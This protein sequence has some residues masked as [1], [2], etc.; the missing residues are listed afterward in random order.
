MTIEQTLT[1]LGIGAVAGVMAGM[2][3]LGGGAIIVPA[4]MFLMG[5]SQTEANGTSL[6]ALV[7]PVGIFACIAYYRQGKLR[8]RSSAAT[9]LGL[10]MGTGIGASIALGLPREVLSV[11][12]G[13][14]LVY[15]GWRYAS[16]RQWFLET[17]GIPAP[18]V[19]EE[20]DVDTD[21]LPVIAFCVGIGVLA[22]VLGGMFGIGGGTII[23]TA[24]V[25]IG[26]DH[27]LA[28]GTSLGALLLPVGLPAAVSYYN[29][30]QLN[31]SAVLPLLSTLVVFQIFG[32]RMTLSLPASTVKRLF[33]VFLLVVSLRYLLVL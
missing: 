19:P 9:A 17:R 25:A 27:K 6:A 11:A 14:F 24:L 2:F 5:F 20:S 1:L 4:L 30:G 22:G 32:A 12:Y 16:P 13:V 3:G 23:I 18:P 31:L 28:T 10:V 15:I 8:L 33:G 21:A 29:A 26:F 7:L